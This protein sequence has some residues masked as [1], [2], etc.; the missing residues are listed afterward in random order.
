MRHDRVTRHRNRD[1]AN[2]TSNP[3][4][5]NQPPC[6]SPGSCRETGTSA[7]RL[8]SAAVYSLARRQHPMQTLPETD[9]R[10][11]RLRPLVCV[12]I[13]LCLIAGGVFLATR[14]VP[15]TLS[16][17]ERPLAPLVSKRE[18][19]WGYLGSR[20]CSECHAEIARKYAK[21]PM[22]RSLTKVLD[23]EVV[24]DYKSATHVRPKNSHRHYRVEQTSTSVTHSELIVSQ[25]DGV[26]SEFAM[27]IHLALG[28]G[29]RGRS[30]LIDRSNAWLI[31]PVSW[32][33]NQ[34][35]W[36]LSP[37]YAPENHKRFSREATERCINCHSGGLRG[38]S[39]SQGLPLRE[40]LLELS[41]GCERCHGPGE[42]HVAYRRDEQDHRAGRDPILRISD[43][44]P[45]RRDAVCNQCH[46]Q[47]DAEVLRSG[48]DHND[49]RPGMHLGEVWAI[50][51][52]KA[53]AA[54]DETSA[55]SQVMQM[56][57]SACF[58][59]SDHRLGCISCHD[60]HSTPSEATRVTWYRSRCLTCHSETDCGESIVNRQKV[61]IDDSCIHCHMPPLNADDVPHT[62]QTDHRILRFQQPRAAE[63]QSV[64]RLSAL[65]VI[66]HAEYS[67]HTT[68]SARADA[69]MRAE[70]AWL[71]ENVALA[72][73]AKTSLEQVVKFRPA[74][75]PSHARLGQLCL[76]LGDSDSA[77]DHWNKALET[78]QTS[79]DSTEVLQNLSRLHWSRGD[80]P[81]ARNGYQKLADRRPWDPL[82]L[83]SLSKLLAE[84]G[85][86]QQALVVAQ[87][88]ISV[89][90]HAV[91]AY[92]WL[93]E[94]CRR[95]GNLTDQNRY[96]QRAQR[97][98]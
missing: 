15:L 27:E 30:Y 2:R 44:D 70:Q 23:A 4:S 56:K 17:D 79:A 16:P 51:V 68:E 1:L 24:E 75:L 45:A 91:E 3:H 89:D 72:Q 35:R 39:A 49:F 26:L 61:G 29:K 32:Y 96:L 18:L 85:E 60:P 88:A 5:E 42:K 66:D 90:Q 43:L 6:A 62:T 55:V 76:L 48:R 13:A 38:D 82:T 65:E 22:S 94:L 86:T 10:P 14:E 34:Q 25:D 41:I 81:Q 64:P 78:N 53:D 54:G 80:I 19:D 59:R 84:S 87:Q 63:P 21:H 71:T 46:L 52:T 97:L 9:S 83:L 50:F 98:K 7:A 95:S 47:G 8:I 93:A 57:S 11:S 37:G 40:R 92:Q 28:S 36:D 73:R 74:D 67:V 58:Q 77:A 33:S 31:S 69:L 12:G 20:V